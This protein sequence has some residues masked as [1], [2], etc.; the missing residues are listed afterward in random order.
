MSKDLGLV[1]IYT[2]KFE[3][4]RQEEFENEEQR[5]YYLNVMTDTI[6]EKIQMERFS[7]RSEA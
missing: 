4:N 1:T 3:N 5:Y 2:K 6:S 7:L